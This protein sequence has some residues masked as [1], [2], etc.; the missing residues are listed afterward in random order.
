VSEECQRVADAP[1]VAVLAKTPHDC[2]RRVALTKWAEIECHWLRQCCWA[3]LTFHCVWGRSG[4]WNVEV[5]RQ[6]FDVMV[7]HGLPE[8][9]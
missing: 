7:I 5:V 9:Q 8:D 6:C 3:C 4:K 2:G 1:R